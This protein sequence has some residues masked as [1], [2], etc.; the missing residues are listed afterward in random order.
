MTKTQE[1]ESVVREFMILAVN[2]S[3]A[4]RV[5]IAKDMQ[6][7]L[8]PTLSLE[9]QK[10]IDDLCQWLVTKEPNESIREVEVEV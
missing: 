7:R 8:K 5:R 3:Q 6:E 2:K 10:F 9:G 1:F 4:T